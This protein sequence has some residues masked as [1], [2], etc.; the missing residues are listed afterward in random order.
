MDANSTIK[1]TDFSIDS[2]SEDVL[3]TDEQLLLQYRETGNRDFFSQLVKRYE[4][5]LFSYLCR[6]LGNAEMAEDAFQAA[7]LQIHLKCDQLK[8]DADFDHGF[9]RLQPIRPSIPSAVKNDTTY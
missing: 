4:R 8:R 5:E 9:I 2:S 1:R 3:V 7:F 6:Y